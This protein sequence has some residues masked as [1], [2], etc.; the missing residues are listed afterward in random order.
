M[1]R[2]RLQ[3]SHGRPHAR[4]TRAREAA[5]RDLQAS[6]SG[7][8]R[9][10]RGVLV[11]CGRCRVLGEP[12]RLPA[13]M[14]TPAGARCDVQVAPR[15]ARAAGRGGISVRRVVAAAPCALLRAPTCLGSAAPNNAGAGAPPELRGACG[16]SA[17]ATRVGPRRGPRCSQRGRV[18]GAAPHNPTA[19]CRTPHCPLPPR[20]HLA[21]PNPRWHAGLY[22][23]HAGARVLRSGGRALAGGDREAGV[24]RR[25]G[26][27]A[28]SHLR[29]ANTCLLTTI[30]I[31]HR[32]N[33]HDWQSSTTSRCTTHFGSETSGP[34]AA[35]WPWSF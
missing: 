22:H 32:C 15:R 25:C 31:P 34:N 12:T 28:H 26:S 20:P 33:R 3:G 23:G 27:R 17:A 10:T 14:R 13:G 7:A 4:G 29:R 35:G 24:L 21:L 5:G 16:R 6:G 18:C 11:A 9:V 2:G 30:A 19:C 8:R 1:S